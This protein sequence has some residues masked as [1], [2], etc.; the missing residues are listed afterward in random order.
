MSDSPLRQRLAAILAADVAGYS[1]LMAV[2]ERA[3]V[4]TLDASRSVFRMHVESRQG[5]IIDMAGDSVL[6]VFETATGAVN[7]ALA[8]QQQLERSAASQP[9]RRAMRFR[10]G[11]HLGDVMEKA[12]GTVYGEG[13]NIAARLEGL[14]EPSGVTVS[15][16][17]KSALR[18][19]VAAVFQDLGDQRVKNI[20]E[21]VRAYR[22]L[23]APPASAT[24]LRFGRFELQGGARRLLVDGQ[25]A[26]LQP[27]AVDTLLALAER[28]GRLIDKQTLMRLVAPD[29]AQDE[30]GLAERIGELRK[31]VGSDVI[32]SIPGRGYRFVAPSDAHAAEPS[33]SI[34]HVGSDR[35][36]DAAPMPALRTNL[37]SELPPLLG[38]A[39]DLAALDALID[40]HRL[41]SIVGPGGIG[42]SLLAQHLLDARR[43]AYA[44]G[45]CWI[46]L[47]SVSDPAALPGAV[48]AALGVH[49]GH[50]DPLAA[51]IAVVAPLTM[52]LALDNAEHHLA[53][54]AALCRA[55]HEAAPGLRLVVTSQAPLR[56]AAERVLRI[57][58]L[59]VPEGALPVS[60]ALEFGA[61][62][63]F[64]DR[65]QAVDRRFRVSD[66]N[67]PAVIEI[68]RALDGLPLA[69]ELAAAR[70]PML[71]IERLRSSLQH[72]FE[73]LTGGRNRAAPARQRTL[74]AALEWSHE[75]LPEREQ[76]AFRRLGVMAGSASLEL[77]QQVV[78]DAGDTSDLDRWAVL[79]ALDALIDRSMV[80]VQGEATPR[81][82]LLESPRAYALQRL[83][84]AGE[85][86]AAQ[87][88]H[89]LAM[90]ALLD[91]AYD[92]S[93]SGRVGSDDWLRG[94]ADDLDNARDALAWASAS[95]DSV[96]ALTIG[97]TLLR[98]LPP[99]LHAERMAL[100]EACEARIDPSLPEPLQQRVWLELSRAWA[101]TQKLRS[102]DAAGRALGLARRLDP[103]QADRFLLYRAL[104]RSASA[105]AQAGDL[106]AALAPLDELRAIED[107]DWPA[108]RLLWGT[109]AAQVVARTGGD[110]AGALRLARRLLALDRE[111]G[112]DA[113][114]PLGNLIDAELATG[115]ASAAARFGEQL[116]AALQGTRNEYT[117]AYARLNLCAAWLAQDD[118]ARAR[119]VAQAAWPQSVAFE[120]Q[121]YAT[122]YLALLAALERRPHSAARLLGYCEAVYVARDEARETNEAAA[123]SRALGLAQ[124]AIGEANV[125]RLRV[126]GAALRDRD[127]DAL[128]FGIDDDDADADGSVAGEPGPASR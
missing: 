87:R 36:L 58:P 102:R 127:I 61:V 43:G 120:L 104:C 12:D 110:T 25:P 79:D 83:E 99:S 40:A 92:A 73:L 53:A 47:A 8:I 33:A 74:R 78:A 81:Y 103:P 7:A 124:A 41:V 67:A 10:I 48:T 15:D 16:A 82:R 115:D 39:D 107:P 123:M 32:A 106:P 45:V 59:A 38:R 62:A 97:A 30:L 98:A 3:T 37:P 9:E 26:A 85:R 46:E 96:T 86:E 51:L 108:Q 52:L 31:V 111:R 114:I 44:H 28:P 91:A 34:D 90:A 128:A 24:P 19:K 66:A 50:G 63:L 65:A 72:R 125:M 119:S 126:Q 23:A 93:F 121:H 60:Q 4:A 5:R 100:A 6:A 54:V 122:A 75:L 49:G 105:A 1:R 18:G 11:V 84:Q 57:G 35:A 71:G 116:V 20:A 17:V 22:L 101:D 112:S 69:I 42:K 95:G 80:V 68:C 117:L 113:S 29:A 55:L 13:V 88:R 76:R 89:A 109:E 14:A 21:P 94:L 64:A 70:A 27:H 118:C 2:D 56:L 77:V